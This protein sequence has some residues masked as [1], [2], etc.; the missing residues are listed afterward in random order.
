VTT[1]A[2][3]DF[4]G[5]PV[6][7]A[8]D[9][10]TPLFCAAD[11]CTALGIANSRDAVSRL[12]PDD[13]SV[14][15]TQGEKHASFVTE[16]GLY[17]LV[18]GSRKQQARE[19]KK[20]VTSDVIPEIRKRGYYS[21]YEHQLREQREKLLAE[22]FPNAP[23]YARP[24]IS[25]LIEVLLRRF[26][27]CPAQSGTRV[28]RRGPGAPPWAKLLASLLY[29]WSLPPGQQERRR[30]LNPVPA[31]ESARLQDHSTFSDVAREKVR[32]VCIAGIA[33]AKGASAWD[34]WKYRMELAFGT[35]ALQMTI[36]VPLLLPPNSDDGKNSK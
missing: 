7:T 1:L 10:E 9:F 14:Q 30:E 29:H 13:V 11:V 16:A 33:I 22:H 32:D 12:D 20:W 35:K 34:D 3:F 25:D 23:G 19:F 31:G 36:M 4:R 27:W 24:L 21:L 6:R 2:T 26:G 8:G 17:Q 15:P 5:H 28:P 18:L